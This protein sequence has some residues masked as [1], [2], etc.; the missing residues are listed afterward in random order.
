MERTAATVGSWLP[1]ALQSC[2]SGARGRCVVVIGALVVEESP[3]ADNH[4]GSL[5]QAA[6]STVGGRDERLSD[7]VWS[8]LGWSALS[9][10]GQGTLVEK[11]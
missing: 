6:V 5:L 2:Q 9:L 1:A 10:T 7:L 11:I 3:S 4:E 8:G